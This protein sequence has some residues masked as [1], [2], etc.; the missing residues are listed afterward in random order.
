MNRKKLL[1]IGLTVIGIGLL[2]WAAVIW[3]FRSGRVENALKNE[4]T[5]LIRNATGGLYNCSIGSL[6]FDADKRQ[7]VFYEISL[8]PD[9][10]T[11]RK[12]EGEGKSPGSLV[13]FRAEKISVNNITPASFIADKKIRLESVLLHECNLDI[14]QQQLD[15]PAVRSN[16]DS[17]VKLK[18]LYESMKKDVSAIQIDSI[19]LTSLDL[20]YVNSR[21]RPDTTVIRNMD[22]MAT[23]FLLN[24]KTYADRSRFLFTE[25][26]V[27]NLHDFK[28]PLNN[29]MYEVR[30]DTLQMVIAGSTNTSLRNLKLENIYAETEYSKHITTQLERFGIDVPELTMRNFDYRS[31][32]ETGVFKADSVLLNGAEINIFKDRTKK[33][34]GKT[35]V[36]KYPHQL[37]QQSGLNVDVGVCVLEQTKIKYREKSDKTGQTGEVRFSGTRGIIKPVRQFPADSVA[38]PVHINATSR[39]MDQA[40]LTAAFVLYPNSGDGRFSVNGRFGRLDLNTLNPAT[41]PLGE[42]K[43]T[44]GTVEELSFALRGNDY[45]ATTEMR[46]RYKDL[47]VD[48][49]KRNA[50]GNYV[51]KGL[52]SFAANNILLKSSNEKKNRP[53]SVTL[54]YQRDT[55]KSMFNLI[56]KSLFSG[57]KEIAGAGG[58]GKDA[59]RVRILQKN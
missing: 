56:W 36:G 4:L 47:S 11:Y 54:T 30:F 53:E 18:S 32:L 42:V 17:L 43:I 16:S 49:V 15:T 38:L 21:E 13:Y 48:M 19:L 57:M 12:M 39:F 58:F 46:F 29:R 52:L 50:D 7:V 3:L 9:M 35:R 55:D 41:V 33:F 8:S 51:K 27:M 28:A 10:K 26:M 40:L 22:L 1:W 37:L 59:E 24:G 44:A 25:K 5:A 45:A 23:G 14:V 20:K 6:K 2:G 31:F 34:D